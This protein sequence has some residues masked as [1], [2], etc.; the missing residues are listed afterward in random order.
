MFRS[1]VLL[2]VLCLSVTLTTCSHSHTRCPGM[3]HRKAANARKQ[4]MSRHGCVFRPCRLPSASKGYMCTKALDTS[5]KSHENYPTKT[6]KSPKW[7]LINCRKAGSAYLQV[8]FIKQ[9]SSTVYFSGFDASDKEIS[10]YNASKDPKIRRYID[11]FKPSRR[12][13]PLSLPCSRLFGKQ[14][15]PKL[16]GVCPSASEA[17][18]AIMRRGCR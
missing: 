7:K 11:L 17:I 14:A 9:G 8:L 4:C 18:L 5:V 6:A 12:C 15:C 16:S 10:C 2:L 1:L 3:C 13:V